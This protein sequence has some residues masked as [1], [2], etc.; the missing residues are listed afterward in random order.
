[1]EAFGSLQSELSELF[2]IHNE[3]ERQY[4]VQQLGSVVVEQAF[5]QLEIEQT[6]LANLSDEEYLEY[7]SQVNEEP[8][9]EDVPE[10][11]LDKLDQVLGDFNERYITLFG[12]LQEY[13]LSGIHGNSF[14]LLK[15]AT[16]FSE[17]GQI[18]LGTKIGE[19]G[20]IIITKTRRWLDT[21][22]ASQGKQDLAVTEDDE[23]L[24]VEA[25]NRLIGINQQLQTEN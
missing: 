4:I 15:G 11:D 19:T 8:E 13:T 17:M 22:T 2:R 18:S 23:K 25:V 5:E 6:A 7:H 24:L 21:E 14:G 9:P 16:I 1:M 20:E 3:L 10:T 12:S